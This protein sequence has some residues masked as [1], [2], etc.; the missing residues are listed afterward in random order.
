MLA[1]TALAVCASPSAGQS[2]FR[3][4]GLRWIP[5][6]PAPVPEAP[7]EAHPGWQR[8]LSEVESRQQELVD[9]LQWRVD[10]LERLLEQAGIRRLPQPVELSYAP[11]PGESPEA[12]IER[13]LREAESGRSVSPP[14]V[15]GEGAPLEAE[16]ESLLRE[17]ERAR[18]EAAP[19]L[20]AGLGAR[21]SAYNPNISVIG[22]F[23]GLMSTAPESFNRMPIPLSGFEEGDIGGFTFRELELLMTAAVDPYADAMA[24]LAF[25]EHGVEIEECYVLFHDYPFRERLPRWLQDVQTKM[26]LFRT[27]FGPMNAVDDHDLPTVDRPIAI[28]RFLGDEGLLRAGVS[29]SKLV[30][31][32]GAWGSELEVE[33][34]NGPA[35]GG[36]EGSPLFR[37]INH[38][39]GLVHYKV[40]TETEPT[41]WAGIRRGQRSFELGATF[42]ATGTQVPAGGNDLFS[43][44]EGMDMTWQWFDPRP[45]VYRQYLLQ[46][47][48]FVSQLDEPGGTV[49]G[50][51]GTYVLGQMR[52][53]RQWFAGCRYDISEFPERDGRQQAITPYLTWFLSE[54]NRF[55]LQYQYL[56]QDLEADGCEDVHTVWLQ[57]VFAFGAHPPEPYYMTQ[58]Y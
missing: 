33:F 52:L 7:A 36:E 22:D 37:G 9:G 51:V 46:W 55:R 35:P 44:V 3:P 45:G 4:V 58:R 30:P 17:R 50:A 57:L 1:L 53:N 48:L 20:G 26:G 34:T 40:F 39:L 16:I 24:K 8:R 31:L 41:G 14:V 27:A 32:W 43:L 19:E 11:A 23:V 54:F 25:Q 6:T 5:D 21:L 49:R 29:F 2:V 47:E 12:E 56:W 38:P 15:P 18:A 28:Q 42:A 10:R 13:L